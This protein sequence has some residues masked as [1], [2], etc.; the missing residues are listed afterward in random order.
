MKQAWIIEGGYDL[1]L[2]AYPVCIVI[3]SA[4]FAEEC[5]VHEAKVDTKLYAFMNCTEVRLREEE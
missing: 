1:Y 4:E 2:P 3:G 5:R